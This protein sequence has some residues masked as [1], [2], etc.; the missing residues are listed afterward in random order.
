MRHLRHLRPYEA[1]QR[2]FFLFSEYCEEFRMPVGFPSFSDGASRALGCP[3]ST[4]EKW[5]VAQTHSITTIFI[6]ED[7]YLRKRNKTLTI[8]LTEQEY[9]TILRKTLRSDMS[10]TDFL[11]TAAQQTQ[12]YVAEDTKP[13]VTELKRIGNNLNQITAKINAGIFHSYNFQ[14]VIDLQRAVYE[15]ARRIGRGD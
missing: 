4:I 15:E 11:V 9:D 10:M 13:L 6:R 14:E 12:I 1:A 2:I 5:A 7:D 3:P 8:R